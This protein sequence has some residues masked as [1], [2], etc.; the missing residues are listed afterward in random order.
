VARK[1]SSWFLRFA[2]NEDNAEKG[3]SASVIELNRMKRDVK[4]K[5]KLLF[6]AEEEG[7]TST[8][9][10]RCAGEGKLCGEEIASTGI[11]CQLQRFILSGF[12]G[13]SA[14]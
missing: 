14:D 5:R 6:G 8:G 11:I 12:Q 7:S 1:K 3:V 2:V 13:R 4:K 10:S 9:I